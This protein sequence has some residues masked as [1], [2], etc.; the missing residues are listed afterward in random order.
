MVEALSFDA[1]SN[2][3]RATAKL[4]MAGRFRLFTREPGRGTQS[5]HPC[6]FQTRGR[7]PL[8]CASVSSSQCSLPQ[9][10]KMKGSRFLARAL[11]E[12]KADRISFS[13]HFRERFVPRAVRVE[14]LD[15]ERV[16]L[17]AG[18]TSELAWLRRA[19]SSLSKLDRGLVFKFLVTIALRTG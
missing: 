13:S 2:A 12:R 3:Q 8:A 19:P 1:L 16:L 9:T 18:V 5:G 11:C 4:G 10:K 14:P 17:V 15:G 7:I 6:T